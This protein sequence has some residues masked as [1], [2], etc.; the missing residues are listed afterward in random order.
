VEEAKVQVCSSQCSCAASSRP[1]SWFEPKA[2]VDSARIPGAFDTRRVPKAF[3][4]QL[5]RVWEEPVALRARWSA[6]E[7]RGEERSRDRAS[8][9]TTARRCSASKCPQH[10]DS[11]ST[12]A[13]R[14][15][16]PSL[17]GVHSNAF[18]A[19]A[20]ARLAARGYA[21][22]YLDD[23]WEDG[24][25]PVEEPGAR[26]GYGDMQAATEQAKRNNA[27]EGTRA[28]MSPSTTYCA[29]APG[30]APLEGFGPR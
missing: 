28:L 12:A 20:G 8:R 15:P 13:P 11:V 19:N 9:L 22:W 6:F 4:R 7:T 1:P 5:G 18:A 27:L 3:G 2:E 21:R 26:E 30:Q 29:S 23:A 10:A 25:C 24:E 16:S 14:L 17:S